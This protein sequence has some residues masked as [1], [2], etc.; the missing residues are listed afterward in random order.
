MV[1][2]VK[3]G[4]G[5]RLYRDSRP[6]VAEEE[7]MADSTVLSRL[8]R[9]FS[10][11]ETDHD[12]ETEQSEAKPPWVVKPMHEEAKP[13]R[14]WQQGYSTALEVAGMAALSAAGFTLYLWLG[15][16]LLGICLIVMGVAIGLPQRNGP[17]E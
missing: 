10:G 12:D 5:G 11:N 15:L 13:P 8:G 7:E 4:T 6:E 2:K 3:I 14:D 9:Y 16:A 1:D 17:A